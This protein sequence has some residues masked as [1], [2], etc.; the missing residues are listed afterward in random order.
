MEAAAL[1]V[2]DKQAKAVWCALCFVLPSQLQ[3]P[4]LLHCSGRLPKPTWTHP[5]CVSDDYALFHDIGFVIMTGGRLQ[6][7]LATSD[8][9]SPCR[10]LKDRIKD[11]SQ[12]SSQPHGNQR[13]GTLTTTI[14]LPSLGALGP[15]YQRL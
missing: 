12:I 15:K 2:S 11:R 8:H 9:L 13:Q 3:F 10:A 6:D 4:R 5:S 7:A 1:R 14:G